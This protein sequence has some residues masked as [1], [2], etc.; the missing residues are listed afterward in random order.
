M[1]VQL[2]GAV[3]REASARSLWAGGGSTTLGGMAIRVLLVDDEAAYVESLAKVLTRRGFAVR[4]AGDGRAGLALIAAETF[5][6]AVL[7]LKMPGLDGV[8]VLEAIRA[9]GD[10]LTQVLLLSG[11]ADMERFTAALKAGAAHAL[12]KPCPVDE[13]CAAIEDAADRRAAAVAA[14]PVTPS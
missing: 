6:V 10:Q 1:L 12:L 2:E 5:D 14:R 13:L 3:K 4:T 11:H 7:D 8:E 9:R